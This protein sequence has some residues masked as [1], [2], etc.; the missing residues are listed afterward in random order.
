MII[1]TEKLRKKLKKYVAQTKPETY[2]QPCSTEDI[3]QAIPASVLVALQLQNGIW[4]VLL[5]KRS[6]TLE[7][8]PSQISFAGGRQENTDRNSKETALREAE[9]EIGLPRDQVEIITRLNPHLIARKYLVTPYVGLVGTFIP[10]VDPIEV[11]ELFSLPLSFFLDDRHC[12]ADRRYPN[13][14]G[15]Q[16]DY[17]GM[18][19]WG[20]TASILL[21]LKN[22]LNNAA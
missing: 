16:F 12:T 14:Q 18:N 8:H 2:R 5:T 10:K 20:G 17:Q 3:Q 1:E 13:Y 22:V 6:A 9:E 19:I 21:N 15:Y 4:H 11:E 7:D